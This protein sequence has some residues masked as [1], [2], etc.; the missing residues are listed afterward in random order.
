MMSMGRGGVHDL[1][2]VCGPAPKKEGGGDDGDASVAIS[3]ADD[4][5]LLH[6]E[7][8]MHALVV[9]L[10]SLDPPL[11]T[12]H[13]LRRAIEHLD[14]EAY[15]GW[16][17]YDRWAAG[18]IAVLIERG[19]F[20]AEE[21]HRALSEDESK[22]IQD[23]DRRSFQIG[24]IVQVKSEESR[25]RWTK[26]HI[27]CPGYIHGAVGEVVDVIGK[28]SDPFFAAFVGRSI[29]PDLEKETLRP[30]TLLYRVKFYM[31]DLWQL[32][33]G[34]CEDIVEVE[35]Y[36]DWLQSQQEIFKHDVSH[37][38][39]NSLFAHDHD[40]SG[41]RHS[42]DPHDDRTSVE[43]TAIQREEA[44][45]TSSRHSTGPGEVILRAMLYLLYE[46]KH[47]VQASAVMET[48]EKLQKAGQKLLGAEL[49]AR[50]W[51]D[52]EFKQKLLMDGTTYYPY[53]LSTNDYIFFRSS[54]S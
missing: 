2:G 44:S 32:Y 20:T 29:A 38:R 28:V 22:P 45:V 21:L 9:V 46:I 49:V 30:E 3:V 35:V 8:V 50:A 42:H 53:H 39:V 25:L 11:I 54:C 7:L 41:P 31:K 19:V 52:P 1:G 34:G 15:H 23:T 48:V 12:S 14:A 6:W 5:P 18:T 24:N 4:A 27:R 40:H 43:Y 26:P 16:G 37:R 17:Y 36:H 33:E 10:S 51:K 47:V 13:E